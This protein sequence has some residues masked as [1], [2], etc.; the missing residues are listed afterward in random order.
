LEVHL[1]APDLGEI[2]PTSEKLPPDSGQVSTPRALVSPR[3]GADFCTPE[4]TIMIFKAYGYKNES[5]PA[6]QQ[7]CFMNFIPIRNDYSS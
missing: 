2:I 3:F 4:T 1:S 7:G 6:V 5:I